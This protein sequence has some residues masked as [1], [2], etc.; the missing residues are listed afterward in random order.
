[1][2]SQ[3]ITLDFW[4]NDYKTICVKQYD[5]DSRILNISC[6]SNGSAI[7]LQPSHMCNVKMITPDKRNI[8]NPAT[9]NE[10]GTLTVVFTQTMLS[11]S[12]TGKLEIEVIDTNA[13]TVISTMF[14]DVIILGSV[15]P[16]DAIIASDEFNVFKETLIAMGELGTIEEMGMAVDTINNHATVVSNENTLGHVRVDGTTITIDENNM[17]HS[18]SYGSISNNEIDK[19]FK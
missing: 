6:V 2:N 12:G 5:Q 8:Y 19:M 3:K 18:I 16:D 4:R 15:Y 7:K 11:A 9:R 17:I 13:G 14:L 1:M 10:D